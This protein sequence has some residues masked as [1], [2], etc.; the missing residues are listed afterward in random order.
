MSKPIRLASLLL[1]STALVR[2]PR[3]WPSLIRGRDPPLTRWMRPIRRAAPPTEEEV[4]VSIPGGE[5][6]VTGRRNAN[7]E[8]TAPQIVSVPAPPISRVRARATLLER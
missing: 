5:I 3:R 4:D 2:Q 6:V 1:I 8:C 7:I